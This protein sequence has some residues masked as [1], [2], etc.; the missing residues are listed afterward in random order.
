MHDY[1]GDEN[2]L[3]TLTLKTEGTK[4]TVLVCAKGFGINNDDAQFLADLIPF[5][6]GSNWSLKDCFEGNKEKGRLPQKEFINEVAKYKDLKETLLKI[7]GLITG[8]SIHAS[9]SY[10]FDAGYLVQNSRMRA[11][12]GTWITAFNMEDSDYMGGL[13]IDTLTIQTLDMLHKAIDLLIEDGVLEDK[14]SIKA[15]YDVYLHPDVLEY[16][17]YKMWNMFNDLKILNVFQFDTEMGKQVTLTTQPRS[18]FEMT[19]ANTLMRLMAQEGSI[20]SPMET[21]RKHKDNINIW[22]QE[23]KDFGLNADEIETMKKHLGTLYGVADS[24]ESVM[25]LSMDPKISGFDIVLSNKLRKTIAKK[26]ADIL[27]EVK[28]KFYSHGKELGTREVLLD[29]VWQVQI[30]RQLGYSFSLNHVA[31]YSC[32]GIQCM[33]I[34]LRYGAIYWNCAC[35]AVDSGSVNDDSEENTNYGKISYSIGKMK[36]EN[37]HVSLPNINKSKYGFYPDKATNEIIYGLKP[38]QGIGTKVAKA[39]IANQPYTSIDDFYN[40][41][42]DYKNQ[43]TEDGS[44]NTFG[45]KAMITL[46]KAGCFDELENKP[47]QQI[48]EEYIRKISEPLKALKI[49]NIEDLNSLGLLTD[50]QKKYELRLYRFRNYLFNKKFFEK[51]TGKSPNTAYYRLDR[52]FAEPF[53][54]EHFETNMTEGKDYEYNSDGFIIVKRGSIDREFKKLMED[55]KDTVL[56]SPDNLNAVNEIKFKTIWNEKASGSLSKWEMDSMCFYYHEHELANVNKEYH[57]LSDFDSLPKQPQIANKYYF[58]GKEQYRFQLS[59]ICGTV[60]D[61]DKNKHIVTLLTSNGVVNVKFYKGQFGFYDKQISQINS[62]GSKTVLEKSWFT[63]GTKLLI[64]GFRREEQF[65][66]KTYKNSTYKHSVQ[67]IEDINK[68]G[69]LILKSERVNTESEENFIKDDLD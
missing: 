22:Y 12:N 14:G 67:F 44:K 18:F 61:K 57:I 10:I 31:P 1:Y 50:H 29:Y 69:V 48:M 39:V 24:Q 52:K 34:V 27:E 62:D 11:P 59:R 45:D 58:K 8:R 36:K 7:E 4:S 23:M 35:L 51:Q 65:V 9:A 54:F 68:D 42:Q 13:K 20:E 15:N 33:N 21:Y 17:D 32:I 37:I 25:Q 5:E 66:A 55:F 47:R 6:R 28:N 16:N 56:N 40:K 49:S 41:M 64:T 38:I 30:K 46:I 63:R 26:R 60:I 2:V 19:T 3:N 53:F 43:E